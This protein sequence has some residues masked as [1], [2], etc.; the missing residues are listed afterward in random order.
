MKISKISK[1]TIEKERKHVCVLATLSDSEVLL[2][3]NNQWNDEIKNNLTLT[4]SSC[5]DCA[6][7]YVPNQARNV[8]LS[9]FNWSFN[10]SVV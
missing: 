8:P 6:K 1:I 9:S 5:I 7:T 2:E 10:K 3:Q 4:L